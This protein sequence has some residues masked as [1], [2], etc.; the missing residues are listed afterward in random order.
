M[1]IDIYMHHCSEKSFDSALYI[2]TVEAI[3]EI[4]FK[5]HRN[6]ANMLRMGSLYDT[7]ATIKQTDTA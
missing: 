5:I 7:K 3:E 1:K 4:N 6:C 2:S